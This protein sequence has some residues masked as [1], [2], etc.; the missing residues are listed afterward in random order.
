[1]ELF[2]APLHQQ[3]LR[4][5]GQQLRHTRRAGVATRRNSLLVCQRSRLDGTS[6]E[7][8]DH[9]GPPSDTSAK[10]ITAPLP[11]RDEAPTW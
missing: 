7:D 1:M 9:H 4:S 8:P 2:F 5:V 10:R 11:Y 6:V 3:R